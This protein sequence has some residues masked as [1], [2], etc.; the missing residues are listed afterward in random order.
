MLHSSTL[1]RQ[2]QELSFAFAVLLLV[3]ITEV[4]KPIKDGLASVVFNYE[5]LLLLLDK[6]IDCH[7]I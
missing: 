3:N 1:R 2:Q 7:A 5:T 6:M 4:L